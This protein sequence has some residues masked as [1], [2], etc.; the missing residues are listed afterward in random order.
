MHAPRY[1]LAVA[2]ALA[3]LLAACGGSSAKPPVTYR[4]AGRI[5][6]L[7]VGGVTLTLS[8]AASATTTTDATGA[9]RPPRACR[10]APT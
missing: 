10:P 5:A 4:L 2:A 8:G 3:A 6:G 9:Y 7:D 1:R